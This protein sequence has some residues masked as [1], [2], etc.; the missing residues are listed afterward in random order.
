MGKDPGGKE[1]EQ[2][3]EGRDR[4]RRWWW[5]REEAGQ[6]GEDTVPKG[7][8]GNLRNPGKAPRVKRAVLE[9]APLL[10]GLL[11]VRSRHHLSQQ[12]TPTPAPS[13]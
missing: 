13:V 9:K 10:T 12:P 7:R 5:D 1:P 11:G 4:V 6:R 2:R 8:W 3:G